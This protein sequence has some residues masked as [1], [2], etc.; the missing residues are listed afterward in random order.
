MLVQELT[1]Q[2][3]CDVPLLEWLLTRSPCTDVA[4]SVAQRVEYSAP[5]SVFKVAEGEGDWDLM[6]PEGIQESEEIG[7]CSEVGDEDD[8]LISLDV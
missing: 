1:E 7:V 2:G 4:N 3:L 8:A 6:R 5:W